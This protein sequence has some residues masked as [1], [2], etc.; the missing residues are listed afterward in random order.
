MK[1]LLLLACAALLL[2]GCWETSKGTKVGIIVKCASEG[3]LSKTYECELVRG[4]VSDGSGTLGKSFHFTAEHSEMFSVLDDALNNQ[5]QVRIKYHTEL[6][7]AP[8][9]TETENAAFVDAVEV[10]K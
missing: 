9:R 10:V 5:R 8:W 6:M 7:A 3:I 1:K 4:G 2:Q